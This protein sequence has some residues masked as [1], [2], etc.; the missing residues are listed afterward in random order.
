M[1]SLLFGYSCLHWSCISN[2]SLNSLRAS[3]AS[4]LSSL[5]GT[6]SMA[7]SVMLKSPRTKS[8]FFVCV[9]CLCSSIFSQKFLWSCL[10]FGAYTFIRVV[11]WSFHVADNAN[12]HPFISSTTLV[13]FTCYVTVGT[14]ARRGL[15]STAKTL[16]SLSVV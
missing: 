1:Y 12:A 4:K 7:S 3:V 9:L 5:G 13:S 11:S 10:L 15:S 14:F 6:L 16:R 8:G 2:V